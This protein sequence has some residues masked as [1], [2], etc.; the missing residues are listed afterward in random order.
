MVSG[1]LLVPMRSSSTSSLDTAKKFSDT[2]GQKRPST[3]TMEDTPLMIQC[4][5]SSLPRS[6][7][8]STLVPPLELLT[9]PTIFAFLTTTSSTR[10]T[11]LSSGCGGCSSLVCPSSVSSTD[12]QE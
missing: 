1:S 7:V 6:L 8:T 11:S 4:A 9:G 12:L 3:L 2:F 10:S 5:N